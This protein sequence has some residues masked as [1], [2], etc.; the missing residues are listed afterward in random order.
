MVIMK[1]LANAGKLPLNNSSPPL[2]WVVTKPH[3][4]SAIGI[5]LS[6]GLLDRD[7]KIRGTFWWHPMDCFIK[8][9]GIYFHHSGGEGC[10]LLIGYE[11]V[12]LLLLP[13]LL[14]G[15]EIYFVLFYVTGDWVE[16]GSS[17]ILANFRRLWIIWSWGDKIS[18]ILVTLAPVINI[19]GRFF[20]V[21]WF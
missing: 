4:C 10:F 13:F 9:K 5:P 21:C 14:A 8:R 11:S 2:F 1:V 18:V 16:A 6:W 12:L 3:L 17:Q 20:L 19:R 7:A 15:E